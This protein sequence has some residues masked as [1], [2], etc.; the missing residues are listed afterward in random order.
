MPSSSW[1]EEG[2]AT[3]S[4][5]EGTASKSWDGKDWKPLTRGDHL[6]AGESV[7]SGT[8][9]RLELTLPDGSNV[10]FSENTNF[11]VEASL[12]KDKERAVM[13]QLY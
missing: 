10:R 2:K 8:K 7:K 13:H 1:S 3:V 12:F 4:Y 5:L 9:S 6:S 11:K